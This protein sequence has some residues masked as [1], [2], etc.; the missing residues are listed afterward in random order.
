MIPWKYI[1][2]LLHN[3]NIVLFSHFPE[4]FISC[5]FIILHINVPSMSELNKLVPLNMLNF[6]KFETLSLLG[7]SHLFFQ[8]YFWQL[9]KLQ[10]SLF[11]FKISLLTLQFFVIVRENSHKGDDHEVWKGVDASFGQHLSILLLQ[12]K[13]VIG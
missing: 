11:C 13:W 9:F 3:L 12:W 1:L 7:F 5:R 8:F 4:T 6:L 10:P 2:T